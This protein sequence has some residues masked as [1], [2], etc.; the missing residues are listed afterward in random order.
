[1]GQLIS[2]NCP[3]GYGERVNLGAGMS[4]FRDSC[5]Y[6][7]KCKSCKSIFSGDLF[8]E[9]S[10][11]RHCASADTS[12]YEDPDLR[13]ESDDSVD[14]VIASWRLGPTQP[15]KGLKQKLLHYLDRQASYYKRSR[16]VVIHRDG[17]LCPKCDEFSLSFE[18]YAFFD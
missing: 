10:T 13:T 18:S 9:T 12:C 2:G 16:E 11:C 3:C 14:E 1:M 15:P 5:L 7:Y 6:P 8:K 4:N 17:Y